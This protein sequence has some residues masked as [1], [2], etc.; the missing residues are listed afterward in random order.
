VPAEAA[1]E[2]I[3]IYGKFEKLSPTKLR[4][5]FEEVWD[6]MNSVFRIGA[7]GPFPAFHARN[8]LSNIMLN[9]MGG[10][11]AVKHYTNAFKEFFRTNENAAKWAQARGFKG[12]KFD[13]RRAELFG[14]LGLTRGGQLGQ[15]TDA[16]TE[17]LLRTQTA[18]RFLGGGALET[19]A[20]AASVALKFARTNKLS[21]WGFGIGTFVE[22]VARIAHFLAKKEKGFT[23][24]E[25]VGSV[26]KFLF[27]YSNEALNGM[28]KTLLNRLFFFY[29]WQRFAL[30]LVVNTFLEDP[31]RAAILLKATTQPGVERPAGIPEFIREAAGIPAGP[32]DPA[33]GEQPF[34]SRFGSP[35]EVLGQFDPTVA[36]P[37]FGLFGGG[38]K[39][40]R[41]LLQQSVPMVRMAFEFMAEE[42]FFLGRDLS[43]LDKAGALQALIGEA[44][45]VTGFGE[46]V[47]RPGE[48]GRTRFRTRP[49]IRFFL[50]NLPTSRLTQTISRALEE[51]ATA[52]GEATGLFEPGAERGQKSRVEELLRSVFGVSLADVDVAEEARRRAQRVVGGELGE[53]Q[54]AGEVGR[55]PIFIPTEKTRQAEGAGDRV[56]ELL[57]EFRR[58]SEATPQLPQLPQLPAQFQ[59]SRLGDVNLPR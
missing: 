26:N 51:P 9:Y 28:E 29:R 33:T 1:A 39:L 19:G 15:I 42:D 3:K 6:P 47:A 37:Q 40:G 4:K 22:D 45:G 18:G 36:G 5:F 57:D 11:T 53:A 20:A 49:D 31:R 2:F 24:I 27:D 48:E 12:V 23:N 54:L 21:K 8:F 30:P 16:A 25:A 52:I 59:R 44:T 41:E 58:I 43:E 17:E 10:V 32:V 38:V 7:T 50:R 35:L 46:E 13:P 14:G 34:V 56:T 55:L